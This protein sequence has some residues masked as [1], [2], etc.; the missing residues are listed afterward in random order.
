MNTG[1]F[2]YSD[3]WSGAS[4]AY[5]L[6]LSGLGSSL[7]SPRGA[8]THAARVAAPPPSLLGR[9][10]DEAVDGNRPA[11]RVLYTWTTDEQVE[12]LT[13]TPVLLTRSA[14]PTK[15]CAFFDRRRD[16]DRSPV[17]RLFDVPALAKRRFAWA[18]PWATLRGWSDGESYGKRLVRVTLKAE[19]ILGI[20]DPGARSTWRFV[21]LAGREVPLATVYKHPARIAAVYHVFRGCRV[22]GQAVA[23][24]REYVLCNEAMIEAW[25]VGTDQVRADLAAEVALL[26]MLRAEL[27]TAHSARELPLGSW[28]L[29]VARTT[30]RGAQPAASLDALYEASLAFA[31]DRYLLAPD[32]LDEVIEALS[33]APLGAPLAHRPTAVFD[34]R[35]AGDAPHGI[36]AMSAE[37]S[38]TWWP[39]PRS[40]A[41]PMNADVSF[42][43][44]PFPFPRAFVETKPTETSFTWWPRPFVETK[45]TTEASFTWWPFPFPRPFIQQGG[46]A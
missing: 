42:T 34:A 21:D 23:P 12:E 8:R 3:R 28:S 41:E 39:F 30:W 24:F 22:D 44:W 36:E 1:A 20:F 25:E 31:N 35:G 45:A 40:F 9:L 11:R 43:W 15:G 6:S 38:F 32:A 2:L 37:A 7:A 5:A 29:D 19:G 10:A 4:H 13:R 26:R 27:G 17:A 18:N 33:T 14:S 46:C 16:W